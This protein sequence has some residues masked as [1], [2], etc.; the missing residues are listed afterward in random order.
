LQKFNSRQ[1]A[2]SIATVVVVVAAFLFVLLLLLL[3]GGPLVDDDDAIFQTLK[4]SRE[5]YLS[6]VRRINV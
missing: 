6:L 4:R 3:S 1:L 5:G 2:V